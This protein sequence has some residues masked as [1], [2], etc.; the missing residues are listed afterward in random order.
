MLRR[1]GVLGVTVALL[2]VVGAEA[3]QQ[4]PQVTVVLRS[5]ERVT[6]GLQDLA[7]DRFYIRTGMHDDRRIPRNDVSLLDFVGGASGLPETE[8]RHARGDRHAMVLRSGQVVVGQFL[9]IEGGGKEKFDLHVAF[10]TDSGEERRVRVGEVGRVYMGRFDQ[11]P[12]ASTSATAGAGGARTIRVPANSRWVDTML[13]VQQG[14]TVNLRTTGEVNVGAGVMAGP[15]GATSAKAPNRAP[16]PNAGMG[17]LVGRVGNGQA[18]GIG[19]QSSFP[20]PATGRLYLMVNDDVVS[21]NSG[22]FTVELSVV[23][24]VTPTRR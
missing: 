9:G 21:D 13:S 8:L 20:A 14:Q 19:D 23:G 11:S 3:Q 12:T 17:A 1:I 4:F 5:G 18:F 15:A 10:R 2:G 7:N 6:G 22:E 24:G 16:L